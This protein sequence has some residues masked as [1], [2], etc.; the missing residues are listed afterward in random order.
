M[1]NAKPALGEHDPKTE[2]ETK[3]DAFASS[4]QDQRIRRM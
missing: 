2:W 1:K 3:G 4:G